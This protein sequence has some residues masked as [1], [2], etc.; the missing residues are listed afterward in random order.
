MNLSYVHKLLH[1]ADQQRHGFLRVRGRHAHHAVRLMVS[2]GL[3][4]ATFSDGEQSF[5]I[6]KQVTDL[7]DAFL[8]AFK[9]LPT[10]ADPRRA[11]NG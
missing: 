2:A 8:R 6:I 1:A 7:G 4:D 9:D 3:V 5:T 10:H 11:R